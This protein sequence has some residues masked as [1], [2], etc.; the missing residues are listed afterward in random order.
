MSIL[1][2]SDY[3]YDVRLTRSYLVPL[4]SDK[5]VTNDNEAP[6]QL[7]E[8]EID[9]LIADGD[10]KA[11]KIK[12]GRLESSNWS[13]T[14]GSLFNLNAG[15]FY[16][17]GQASP[18]LS[19]NGSVLAVDGTITADSGEIAG[20]TIQANRLENG[21][22][23]IHST[24]G[25]DFNSVFTVD[26]TGQ[27]TAT[28]GTIG[29][30]TLAS[31]ELSSG[32]MSIDSVTGI[33]FNSVFTVD[34]TGAMS[35]TSGTIGG[36]SINA[37]ELSSGSMLID[38]VTGINFNSVF[39]VNQAGA[40]TATS[41]TIGGWTLGSDLLKSAGSGA[42]IELSQANNRVSVF[43]AVNEK[44]AMG[45]L[46]GL[47]KNDAS[48]NWASTDYGFWA[49]SG[50]SIQVD[51]DMDYA[52]GDFLVQNDASVKIL[53]GSANEIIRLGTDTGEK[54]LFIYNT[55]GAQLAKYISDE[56]YIG[57]TGSSFQYT[58]SGG[59]VVDGLEVNTEAGIKVGT[60]GNVFMHSTSGGGGT[61]SGVKWGDPDTEDEYFLISART[62]SLDST[63][64]LYIVPRTDGNATKSLYVGSIPAT[65][66]TQSFDSAEFYIDTSTFNGD[67]LLTGDLN[68]RDSA[69]YINSSA[70]GYL[71]LTADIGINLNV[72]DVYIGSE[73][74][75]GQKKLHIYGAGTGSAEGGELLLYTAAD[76]DTT[77]DYYRIDAYEDDLRIG[78]AG[79]TD[80]T[81]RSDGK[82]GIG[83][84]TPVSKLH[85]NGDI[86]T[87]QFF[88]VDDV[89]AL[90]YDSGNSR[91]E[92][93]SATS[94][95][96]AFMSGSATPRMYI[97]PT[98]GRLGVGT[99]S[100][101]YTIHAVSTSTSGDDR[102]VGSENTASGGI[103]GFAAKNNTG[104][105]LITGVGGSTYAAVAAFT[106]KPFVN[107]SGGMVIRS[108]TDIEFIVNSATSATI[109]IQADGDMLTERIYPV[110]D[111][112][113]DLGASSFRW[114]DVY[115]TN[116]T[117]VTSDVNQKENIKDSDLGLDFVLS[118]RVISYKRKGGKRT[119]YG[120]GAQYVEETLNGKDFAGLI[121][122]D[123]DGEIVYGLRYNEMVAPLYKAI[124]EQQ[125]VINQLRKKLA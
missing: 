17:G 34:Q 7:T 60:L 82:V 117:I 42:R 95:P 123:V 79:T 80:I 58:T 77:C 5:T 92:I 29:G 85:V 100:P 54:G 30:W 6:R 20:W 90:T 76:H 35:A 46:D 41:G 112:L 15:T 121:K 106:N 19:W 110:T 12:S 87:T 125:E 108:T 70:D 66:P 109:T 14:E 22:M 74:A 21:N 64:Y 45:Y 13:N 27:V 9:Q 38:S 102:Y 32:N 63:D 55:S 1:S 36:W 113:Y 51:G 53:D 57:S 26:A 47:P 62:I 11:D 23:Q 105:Q 4:A 43:D 86:N 2:L 28:S 97:G 18:K 50:D 31:D 61:T 78:R 116:G 73:D 118:Q 84:A 104:N 83:T 25:I 119:H 16:L 3:G 111:N 91:I 40:L 107:G 56:I 49:R 52:S 65:T 39:T 59:L 33:D 67:V 44:V 98:N 94:V 93:G 24:N 114:D 122:S 71:D 37:D 103:G 68:F 72:D 120:F 96:L 10:L 101:S 81:L 115:A 8:A 99:V 69:I 48:G 75:G 124:Q 89:A 88:R